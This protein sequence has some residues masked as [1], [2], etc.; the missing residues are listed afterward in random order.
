MLLKKRL[1]QLMKLSNLRSN[2]R[3][4]LLSKGGKFSKLEAHSSVL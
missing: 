4:N 1:L 2:K 3:P